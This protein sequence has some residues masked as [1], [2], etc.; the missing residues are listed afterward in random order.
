M[1]CR[2]FD[3]QPFDK[4][5]TRHHQV[6]SRAAQ[7]AEIL[8]DEIRRGL[9]RDVLP[10]EWELSEHLQVSRPTLRAALQILREEGKLRT[11]KGQRTRL[12]GRHVRARAERG[13]KRVSVIAASAYHLMNSFS[14]FL[15]GKLQPVIEE[16]GLGFEVHIDPR[17]D[18]SSMTKILD[19]LAARS[20][21]A[22]CVQL[23][24][25]PSIQAW[26]HRRRIP[27]IVVGKALFQR[28]VYSLGTDHGAI[29]RHAIATMARRG[30]SRVA[31]IV[32]HPTASDSA[33]RGDAWGEVFSRTTRD[34]GITGRTFEMDIEAWGILPTM[35]R[36]LEA[37]SLPMGVLVERPK[38]VL[39]VTSYLLK[40]QRSIPDDVSL[41]SLGYDPFMDYL[42]PSIAHYRVDWDVFA[43]RL[44]RMTLHLAME[45]RLPSR[46]TL[47]MSNFHDGESLIQRAVSRG[48]AS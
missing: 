12:I 36:L 43:K 8:R 22:C 32:P 16:A 14:M 7:V 23:G 10:G 19:R 21:F 4:T 13:P 47:L 2:S 45:G 26:F 9:Y 38:H 39:A 5:V 15:I 37:F 42:T 31:L 29:C 40:T 34:F 27:L 17:L 46:P 44:I 1:C 28:P 6:L 35:K 11:V 41:I 25:S 33:Y 18:G 30:I 3:D 48:T 24:G 20:D